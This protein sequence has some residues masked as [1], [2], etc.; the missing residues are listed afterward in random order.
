MNECESM[1]DLFWKGFNH[2]LDMRTE[3]KGGMKNLF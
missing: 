2:K 1:Q 3:R